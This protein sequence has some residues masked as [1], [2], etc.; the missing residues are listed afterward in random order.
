MPLDPD[1]T[2]PSTGDDFWDGQ[3]YRET[4]S[5]V[6]DFGEDLINLLDPNPGEW[7]LDVGCGTG[8]LS[9]KL[10]KRGCTVVGLDPSAD[11]LREAHREHP[12][13]MYVR[14][15]IRTFSCENSFHAAF[16]NAALHW[17]QEPDRALRSINT[18]LK[19]GGRFVAEMGASG[20]V[21][22][23]RTALHEEIA[24]LGYD[25]EKRD[26]WFFPDPDDYARRLENAG[27]IVEDLFSFDRPT[28]L[29]GEEGLTLWLLMFAEEFLVPLD[30]NER[31][32]L[33]DTLRE[34]LREELY[35]DGRWILDYQRLR[36]RARNN[37]EPSNNSS[38]ELLDL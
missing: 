36:F 24:R 19:P 10:V 12:G 9:A 23:V 22:T 38:I 29:F 33:L 34:R 15:D 6:P 11:M 14:G 8:E 35:Q 5:F 4:C 2:K 37:V 21:R 7:L 26:P 25:P 1:A 31:E 18:S 17:V 20:N 32:R 30:D 13:P 16:S 28:E 3:L 27:F